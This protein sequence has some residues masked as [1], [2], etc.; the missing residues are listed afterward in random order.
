MLKQWKKN[1]GLMVLLF[2]VILFIHASGTAAAV[3]AHDLGKDV[4]LRVLYSGGMK[5]NI[6]PCG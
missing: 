3:V 5:G 4:V 1:I 2:N 6:E